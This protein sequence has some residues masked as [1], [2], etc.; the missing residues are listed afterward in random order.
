MAN[1]QIQRAWKTTEVRELEDLYVLGY[2]LDAIGEIMERPG[3]QNI[4]WN[5]KRFGIYGKH[6]HRRP[7]QNG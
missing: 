3:R 5:L 4:Y 6:G 1:K 2:T 7:A